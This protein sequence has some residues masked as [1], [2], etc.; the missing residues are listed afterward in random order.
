[1]KAYLDGDTEFPTICGTGSEDYAGLAWGMQ[2]TPFPY[3]G[4]SL[5]E[6]RFGAEAE[7]KRRTQMLVSMY[8]WHLPDPV[9]WKKDC[10]ITIQQLGFIKAPPDHQGPPIFKDRNDDWSAAAFW[11][12]PTPS[13][14]LPPLQGAADRMADINFLEAPPEAGK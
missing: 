8:R 4:C 10:R 11:Y 7:K 12:E 9:Y 14:P 1:M 5:N 6:P 13:A 2:A 3:N